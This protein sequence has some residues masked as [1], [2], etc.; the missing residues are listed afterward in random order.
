MCSQKIKAEASA[1][2][3]VEEVFQKEK[4]KNQKPKK[5]HQNQQTLSMPN[6]SHLSL[7]A[8]EISLQGPPFTFREGG[9]MNGGT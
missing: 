2:M 1:K 6:L 8:S 3:D 5:P 7:I 4:K 9:K